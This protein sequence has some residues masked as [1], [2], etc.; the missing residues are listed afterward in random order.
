MKPAL[1]LIDFQRDYLKATG[2]EPAAGQVVGAAAR[3]LQACRSANVPIIHVLTTVHRET[4]DRMPHWREAGLWRCVN[5]TEGHE[6]PSVLAPIAGETVIHKQFFSGFGSAELLQKLQALGCDTLILAGVH[7]HACIRAT[8]FDAYQ[9]GYRVSIAEDAVASDDPIHGAITRRYL[10]CRAARFASVDRLIAQLNG[11]EDKRERISHF[12]PD[13]RRHE[14]WE[15]SLS[16]RA[17]TSVATKAA[18]RAVGQWNARGPH[19]RAEALR[20]WAAKLLSQSATLAEQIVRDIGKPITQARGEIRRSAELLELA[21]AMA[22]QP[23][24]GVTSAEARFRYEPLGVVAIITPYNNPVG[25]P[26]GKI[27][28]ALAYG[29]TVVWKPALAASA[30]A[31]RVLELAHESGLPEDV[32]CLCTG[33][34]TTAVRLAEDENVQGVTLSGS[35]QAGYAI[36]EICARRHIP[37]QGELGGNNAAI[38]WDDADLPLAAEKIA[39][40]AFGF[41]G[42]RCTANRRVIVAEACFES[43]LAALER[44]TGRLSWGDPSRPETVV[45][46]LINDGKRREVEEL[47]RRAREIGLKLLVPHRE[48]ADYA[49]L[50]ERGSYFSPT[51]VLAD[52]PSLEIVQEESFAPVLVVQ[53]A[54]DFDQATEL[55]NGVRQGLIAAI[56]S[57]SSVLHDQFLREARA[58]VLKINR[59]TADADAAS[60]LGG[61]KASG[62]GPAEHGPS[63]REFY[64]R[65]QTIYR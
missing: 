38:V 33:D 19:K 30:V 16:G 14:L 56:F 35:A 39:E 52:D 6:S 48:Q 36:Q 58:G 24:G 65:V 8:A 13:D 23:S 40:G 61:W 3:L 20:Q 28:P 29:N 5:G 9:R 53:R 64:C 22:V 10:E 34:R 42:Q 54:K 63:D 31:Q 51:I 25:I 41:A 49:Y 7:L 18:S 32:L 2:L 43:F 62:V 47:I 57:A 12:S 27:G 59:A 17:Q 4:D 15:A 11:S 37:Y 55:C 21:A 60:P 1:V 44:A 26:A 50:M 45:G 46:P